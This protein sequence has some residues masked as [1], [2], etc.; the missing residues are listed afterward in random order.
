MIGTHSHK[1]EVYLMHSKDVVLI[2]KVNSKFA[3]I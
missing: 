3:A 2:V 1:T